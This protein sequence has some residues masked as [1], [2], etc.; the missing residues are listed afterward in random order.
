MYAKY[1]Y[2]LPQLKGDRIMFHFFLNLDK[3]KTTQIN[4]G[5]KFILYKRL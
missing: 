4:L 2:Q 5:G 1:L 3:Q